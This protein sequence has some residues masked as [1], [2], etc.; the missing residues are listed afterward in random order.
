MTKNAPMRVLALLGAVLLGAI[1][2][3]AE[4]PRLLRVLSY[5]IHHGEGTDGKLDLPRIANIIQSVK[6]DLVSLQE[7]DIKTNRVQGVDQGAELARLTGMQ[8]LPGD[9]IDFGG[10]RYGNGALVKGKVIRHQNHLLPPSTIEQRGVLEIHVETAPNTPRLRFLATHL[11]HRGDHAERLAS[12]AVINK[13]VAPDEIPSI[14]AG[15]LNATPDSPVLER[16]A[17]QWQ[18]STAGQTL[19][20]SPA[21]NPRNQIDYVLFRPGSAWRVVETRVLD[22]PVASD[23]RPILVVLQWQGS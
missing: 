23:H 15:D 7:V 2:A 12:A 8:Y 18:N 19:L 16:F 20:T 1:T 11:D 10:G 6:P 13:L 4:E 22:E 21:P 9:N 17:E 3:N 5:N 14:L